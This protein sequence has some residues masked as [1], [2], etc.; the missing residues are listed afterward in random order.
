MRQTFVIEAA[1]EFRKVAKGAVSRA[2]PLESFK[3]L[4][5][6]TENYVDQQHILF[7]VRL[8]FCVPHNTHFLIN[9]DF[10]GLFVLFRGCH[11]AR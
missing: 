11:R 9:F 3:H 1:H 4:W 6:H 2:M 8:P 5:A 10:A 7:A